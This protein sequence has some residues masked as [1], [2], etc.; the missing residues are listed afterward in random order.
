MAT[1]FAVGKVR[2]MQV[3]E[4]AVNT[5]SISRPSGPA[6]RPQHLDAT[7]RA[8][9]ASR[10][11]LVLMRMCDKAMRR[12]RDEATDNAFNLASRMSQHL[13]CMSELAKQLQQEVDKTAEARMAFWNK[14]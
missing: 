11:L 12:M 13:Y 10:D 1:A 5:E 4:Q 7:A 6:R 9:E 14:R 2:R 8:L 3:Q